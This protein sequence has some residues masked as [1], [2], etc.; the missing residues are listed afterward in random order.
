MDETKD[1]KKTALIQVWEDWDEGQPAV[2]SR[3]GP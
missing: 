3:R 1:Q 2:A